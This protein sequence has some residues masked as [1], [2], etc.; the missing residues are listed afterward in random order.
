MANDES[1]DNM[2]HILILCNVRNSIPHVEK[3]RRKKYAALYMQYMPC[4]ARKGRQSC[5]YYTWEDIENKKVTEPKQHRRHN[6]HKNNHQTKPN[7]KNSTKKKSE[8]EGNQQQKNSRRKKNVLKDTEPKMRLG[9][10][11][12]SMCVQVCFAQVIQVE[13]VRMFVNI[14]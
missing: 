1:M 4:I 10:K 6:G 13:I 8:R 7:Q 12:S 11:K 9:E 3:K 14:C 2:S 5:I